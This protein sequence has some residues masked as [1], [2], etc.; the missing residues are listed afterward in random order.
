MLAA[1]LGFHVPWTTIELHEKHEVVTTQ[2][3][4]RSSLSLMTVGPEY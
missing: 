3:A 1:T 2:S 4:S